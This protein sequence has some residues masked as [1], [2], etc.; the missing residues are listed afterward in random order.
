MIFRDQFASKFQILKSR[1]LNKYRA[2]DAVAI[3]IDRSQ[4]RGS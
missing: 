2:R 1:T 4:Y 3:Y